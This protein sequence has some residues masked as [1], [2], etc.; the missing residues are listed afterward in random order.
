MR[1]RLMKQT[2][3]LGALALAI[4]TEVLPL[5]GQ[6][7]TGSISGI[8]SDSSDACGPS[9]PV[10]VRNTATNEERSVACDGSGAFTAS[11][12]ASPVPIL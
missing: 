5:V 8:I 12:L 3:L 1:R 10:L 6:T 4:M 9:A 11:L 7:L 2:F